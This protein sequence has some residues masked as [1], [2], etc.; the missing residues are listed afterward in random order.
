MDNEGYLI[1]KVTFIKVQTSVYSHAMIGLQRRYAAEYVVQL[2]ACD[3]SLLIAL[4]QRRVGQASAF[5]YHVDH[6]Y[7]DQDSVRLL[8]VEACSPLARVLP[9]DQ[10]V[11]HVV[12]VMQKFSQ[13]QIF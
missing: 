8:A 13:V 1:F 5:T 9:R 4:S 7:A 12:P 11:Q 10:V 3:D 6:V 2:K